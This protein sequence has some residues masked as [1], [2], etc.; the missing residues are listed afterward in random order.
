MVKV[1]ARKSLHRPIR[2]QKVETPRFLANWDMKVVRLSVLSAG[3]LYPQET[4]LICQRLTRPQCHSG[5]WRITSMKNSSDTIGNRI[6]LLHSA[7]NKLATACCLMAM[8]QTQFVAGSV[9]SDRE[10]YFAHLWSKIQHYSNA[11]FGLTAIH[12]ASELTNSDKTRQA[13]HVKGS[14]E[15]RSCNHD[16]CGK[17]K[18]IT[19]SECVCSLR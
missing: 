12:C 10:S 14:I 16:R 11:S 1:K 18:G 4:V 6:C 3:R 17:A 7:S 9:R 2:L 15:A 19:Y 8:G 5:A 13:T